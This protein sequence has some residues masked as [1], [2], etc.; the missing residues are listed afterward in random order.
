MGKLGKK[1]HT[2]ESK[3]DTNRDMLYRI[4]GFKLLKIWESEYK[5]GEWKQKL[6]DFLLVKD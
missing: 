1:G 6:Y 2:A 3:R 5:S 4:A